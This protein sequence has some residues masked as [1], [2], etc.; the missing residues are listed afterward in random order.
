M[1]DRVGIPYYFEII[2]VILITALLYDCNIQYQRQC[3]L[4]SEN[5]LYTHCCSFIE[6][7]YLCPSNALVFL[8]SISLRCVDFKL[9]DNLEVL[10]IFAFL[11]NV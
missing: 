2:I 4:E 11:A 10:A 1:G 5:K 6:L 7:S 3:G 8:H 9:H